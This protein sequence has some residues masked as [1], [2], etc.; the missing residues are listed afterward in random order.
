MVNSTMWT[1]SERT[2]ENCSVSEFFNF[3]FSSLCALWQL[4]FELSAR[5]HSPYIASARPR[6]AHGERLGAAQVPRGVVGQACKV[7]SP[8]IADLWIILCYDELF[9]T[10]VVDDAKNPKKRSMRSP[11]RKQA[12][13]HRWQS[14]RRCWSGCRPMERC[15]LA[16]ECRRRQCSPQQ[17]DLGRRRARNDKTTLSHVLV[18]LDD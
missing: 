17:A 15:K 11:G 7:S 4:S 9:G 6:S 14:P 13:T 1:P 12:P 18:Q 3:F 5:T 16:L 2:W 8:Q 10:W